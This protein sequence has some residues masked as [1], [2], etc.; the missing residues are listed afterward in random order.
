VGLTVLALFELIFSLRAEEGT[1][2]GTDDAVTGLVTEETTADTA[3]DGAHE[4][5][6]AL[7]RVV[8]IRGVAGVAVR[9][10]GVVGGGRVLAGVLLLLVGV[11]L[12]VRG[13]GLALV[14]AAGVRW[15]AGVAS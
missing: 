11:G 15:T 2:Q 6:L 4:T 3:R 14:E 10:G 7:L 9:V 13:L 5:A 1:R 8:G 12:A